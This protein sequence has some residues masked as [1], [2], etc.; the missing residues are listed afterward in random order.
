MSVPRAQV[1]IFFESF[2]LVKCCPFALSKVYII[3][4]VKGSIPHIT[5]TLSNPPQPPCYLPLFMYHQLQGKKSAAP[6]SL[7][8]KT[9][10]HP[11][12]AVPNHFCRPDSVCLF[13]PTPPPSTPDC[14]PQGRSDQV[15]WRL[16]KLSMIGFYLFWVFVFWDKE[17]NM[18]IL[19]VGQ[20]HLLTR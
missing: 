8:C 2:I 12:A 3:R 18:L 4:T 6:A 5:R 13:A 15:L 11:F 20:C 1:C 9:P 14:L 16:S 19:V 17:R 7:Q 10:P